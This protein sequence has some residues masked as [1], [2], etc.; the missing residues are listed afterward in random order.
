MSERLMNIASGGA[1]YGHPRTRAKP[2]QCI[3]E[4]CRANNRFGLDRRGEPSY[5]LLPRN[6]LPAKL[7]V[8]AAGTF[9]PANSEQV[10]VSVA[11][12][13]RRRITRRLMPFLFILYVIAYLDRVNVSY[14]GLEMTRDLGFSNEVFGFGA[15]IFFVGYF[16]LEIPGTMLV[17]L[18]SARKWIARIMI[19]W[20]L[21]ASLT[22]L[23]NTAHQFYWIRFLLGAAEAGF[24]PGVI[25]YIT[26]WFRYED[27]GKALA[28]FMTAQVVSL[29]LG[30]PVSG[31]LMKLHWLGYAGWRWLLVLEGVPAVV[32]GI[33][34]IF[35]LKDWPKD[36]GWLP[37]EE[38]E[39]IT[40]E[41]D[42]EKQMKKAVTPL[43]V[44][45][46]LRH[47]DVILL[48]LIY[49]FRVTGSYGFT[50]WLPKIVQKLSG[51]ST[52][53][54]SLVTGI[55]YLVSLPA[56]LWVGWHSD[57]TGERRWH[58][59]LPTFVMGIALALSQFV[60]NNVPAAIVMYSIAAMGL[61]SALGCFWA[62]PTLFLTGG[63]AAASIGLINSVGNL[64]GFVGPYAL[65]FLSNKTGNYAA[66]VFF[67]VGSVLLSGFLILFVTRHSPGHREIPGSDS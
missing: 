46:A 20:G 24:F 22:G 52:F 10:A 15:G 11:E 32:F 54:V 30:A 27:R 42:R 59:A 36:A 50:I 45:Q 18:W 67:L 6:L 62:L 40:A 39:W 64:G 51:L 57:K 31:L 16:L 48:T 47:R 60:G 12:R 35:Y 3:I 56:M 7:R 28:M 33:V 4:T 1:G 44:W 37:E 19:S 21:L 23:I 2:G 63:A 25:V 53:Q 9:M 14:A 29:L 49:F 66:G 5:D 38:R 43:S 34:T 26:H 58:M 41:L 13:A 17:E 8:V 61:F 55:P 65:G